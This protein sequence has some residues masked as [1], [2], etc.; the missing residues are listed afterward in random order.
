M[1]NVVFMELAAAQV[2]GNEAS[3]LWRLL[4]SS[5]PASRLPHGPWSR[6]AHLVALVFLVGMVVRV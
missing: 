2:P 3:G 4:C 1:G 5:S 6:G